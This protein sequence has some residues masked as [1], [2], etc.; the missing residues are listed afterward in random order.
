MAG[1]SAGPPLKAGVTAGDIRRSAKNR[2][3]IR[4][5]MPISISMFARLFLAVIL[6]ALAL[7]QVAMACHQPPRPAAQTADCHGMTHPAGREQQEQPD[8]TPDL[9]IG[10]IAPVTVRPVAIAEPLHLRVPPARPIA[11]DGR[12]LPLASPATPPP[13]PIV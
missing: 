5:A 13:R 12:H 2:I 10:C 1:K 3:P 6:A 9:C 11:G 7:P 4:A 8:R